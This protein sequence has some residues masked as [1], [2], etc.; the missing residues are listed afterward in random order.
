M[1][2]GWIAKNKGNVVN[3]AEV[4]IGTTQEKAQCV[5][6]SYVPRDLGE[7]QIVVLDQN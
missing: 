5:S 3:W 1:I 6:S 4:I 7:S 2:K